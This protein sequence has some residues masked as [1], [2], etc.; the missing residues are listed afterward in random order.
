LTTEALA[1]DSD[2]RSGGAQSALDRALVS[3]MAWTAALRWTAHAISWIA[4]AYAAR[5]LSPGD[6]GLV[7][8]AMLGIGLLRMVEDFGMDALLVQDRSIH[9]ESQAR[10]AG[11]VILAGTTFFVLFAGLS[12]A[13][14]GFFHEPKVASLV[15]VLGLLFVFD[16]VQVVPRALLQRDMEFKRLAGLQFVQVIATQT[17]LVTGAALGWGVWAL[18]FN[19]LSG[20]LAATLLLV[21]WRPFAV[22]W[23]KGLSKLARPLLQG[24]RILASRFAWYVYTSADQTVIGRLLGKEALGTYSFAMT[25]STTI[26]QEIG[27]VIGRVVPGIFSAVQTRPHEL[28]RYFLALT[29]LMGYVALPVSFGI[30]ATSDLI[31][32]TVLGPQWD[33]VVAPLRILCLYTAFYSSQVMLGHVLM[34][35]GRFRANMWCNVLTAIVLPVAFYLGS[36]WGLAGIAWGWVVGFPLANLPNFVIAFRIIQIDAW[37]W[38]G[39]IAPALLGCVVMVAAVAIVRMNLPS[40]MGVP[41]Q[42]VVS[43]VTGASVYSLVLV[44]FFGRRLRRAYEYFSMVRGHS[45]PS[46]DPEVAT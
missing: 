28:R 8:M 46:V 25:F 4:T 16:A 2:E 30:A 24:W 11:L 20:A 26:S 29:E 1:T 6:Y 21:L 36:R 38:V 39:A 19:T 27:A 18:V 15:T 45:R 7:G 13:I 40:S 33:A 43:V 41:A 37:K 44:T 17:V 5:I 9:G 23:P 34:W 31:V 32:K 42:L 3:G 12:G 10:L 14:A 35:T 22:G